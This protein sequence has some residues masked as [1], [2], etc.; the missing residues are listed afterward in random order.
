MATLVRGLGAACTRSR[1]RCVRERGRCCGVGERERR[2]RASPSSAMSPQLTWD[3]IHQWCALASDSSSSSLAHAVA[4]AVAVPRE[5]PP[6]SSPRPLDAPTTA[7]PSLV[8]SS[9]RTRPRPDSSRPGS[10]YGPARPAHRRAASVPLLR[11]EM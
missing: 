7:P 5:N 11:A 6:P 1:S 2:V 10:T 3:S 4:R 8:A 9:A